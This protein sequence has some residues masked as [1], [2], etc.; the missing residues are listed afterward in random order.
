MP[1]CGYV[2]ERGSVCHVPL[3]EKYFEMYSGANAFQ[4]KSKRE[5]TED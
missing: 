5:H 2:C 3:E 4:V 1:A